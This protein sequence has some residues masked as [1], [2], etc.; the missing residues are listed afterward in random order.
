M[1]VVPP[2][3]ETRTTE[4][5]DI[6]YDINKIKEFVTCEGKIIWDFGFETEWEFKTVERY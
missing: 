2:G 4:T 6:N 3:L 5:K 1:C